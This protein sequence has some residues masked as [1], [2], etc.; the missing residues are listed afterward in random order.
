MKTQILICAVGVGIVL[1]GCSTA[2][3]AGPSTAHDGSHET[4]A[5]TSASPAQPAPPSANPAPPARGTEPPRK[6]PTDIGPKQSKSSDDSSLTVTGVRTG[7]HPGFTRV[8]FDLEGPGKPGWY[9]SWVDEAT[10][11]GSGKPIALH[12]QSI[13]LVSIDH[14]SSSFDG[15]RY[16]PVYSPEPAIA[17]VFPAGSFEG[18]HRQF[19][20]VNSGR[21]GFD[22]TSLTSPTRLVVD[23]AAS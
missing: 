2:P 15:P 3:G 21:V 8:V 17:E 22:V 7:R 4:G 5:A 11:D 19:I 10:W 20:G 12:G 14:A 6:V 1:S 16:Q 13:L 9:V 18:V 23:I